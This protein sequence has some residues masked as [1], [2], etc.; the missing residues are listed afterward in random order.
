ME[1]HA[2]SIGENVLGVKPCM[3]VTLKLTKRYMT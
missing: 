3:S 1:L 2:R